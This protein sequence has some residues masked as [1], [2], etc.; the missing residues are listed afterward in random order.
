MGMRGAADA[1]GDGAADAEALGDAVG[2][3]VDVAVA[4]GDGSTVATADGA[5]ETSA[6]DE[7]TD[8]AGDGDAP[9]DATTSAAPIAARMRNCG[10][11]VPLGAAWARHRRACQ[12]RCGA[13]SARVPNGLALLLD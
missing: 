10:A 13:R 11:I 7:P 5:I 8:G 1:V 9:Q 4:E 6:A 12:C 3:G 2:D